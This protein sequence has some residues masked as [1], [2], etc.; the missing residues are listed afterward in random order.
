[1][2]RWSGPGLPARSVKPRRPTQCGQ[3]AYDT[4]SQVDTREALED[5]LVARLQ[6]GQCEEPLS[7]LYHLYATKVYGLGIHLLR[8]AGHAE[9][10]GRR[11]S[12][13]CGA[14]R[15]ATTPHGRP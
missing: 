8:D 6:T 2:E 9:D 7:A 15:T 14:R 11:H 4:H 12:F 10:L 1:M 3:P 5:E 13:G